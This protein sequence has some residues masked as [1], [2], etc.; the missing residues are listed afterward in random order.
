MLTAGLV[1]AVTWLFCLPGDLFEGDN[2]STVVLDKDGNLLGARIADDGQWRFPPC[3]SVPYKFAASIIEFEDRQFLSHYGVNP[4]SLVRALWGNIKSGKVTSGGSTITMQVIRLSRHGKDRTVWEKLVEAFM[5]TRLETG[6]S[7]REILALYASHA[8]FGGNVVGLEAAAWRYFGC[9]AGELSWAE[10]ATLAVLP[11]SPSNIHPGKNRELLLAKRNRLLDRLLDKGYISPEE[12]ELAKEEPLILEPSALPNYVPHLVEKCHFTCKGQTVRTSIDLG[13]QQQLD[14]CTTLWSNE[15]ATLGISDLAAVVIDVAS[16]DIIAYCGNASPSRARH[17]AMVDIADS[18]RSTGSVLKP[19]LFCASL[20]EGIILPN[21]LMADTPMNINGFTPRNFDLQY[22]G[23]VPAS[24]ALARSLNVPA[25]NMLRQFGVPKFHEILKELGMTTITRSESDYGL[26]IILGG[27][28]GKLAEITGIYASMSRV[29]QSGEDYPLGDRVALWHT[30]EA[31]KGLGR[32]DEIDLRMVR[33]VRKA[34]WKTGTSWGFRDAWAVGVTPDYA[35]GVWAGN[36]DGS[37]AQGL[38]GARTAGPV[39]FDILNLLPEKNTS[40]AYAAE[41]WFLPPLQSEGIE[42]EVCHKSGHLRGL[43]CPQADTLLLPKAS[44]NS[45]PCPYHSGED[46]LFLLPPAMEWYYKQHHPEYNAV[47]A[48]DRP[49]MEF[50]SP[51]NGSHIRLP[52][53]LD[54]SISSIVF[55]LAHRKPGTTVWWHMDGDYI[56]QTKGIHQKSLSPSAGDHVL[57]VVDASG[58]T[59][60]LKFSIE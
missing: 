20:Q 50:I 2:Y 42:A 56:G 33:S 14:R 36:A 52:R 31:L 21:T 12:H 35:I 13:L 57:T 17:G 60:A 41:G 10:S 26:S 25:V 51:E 38:I 29:Y 58:N 39:M 23:A 15:F 8:P 22:S 16:G 1:L 48:K 7:K 37:G 44:M 19:F 32:P 11:N 27:A 30:F 45:A 40:G 54:G 53:Q 9:P 34:A 43:Y 59:L 47:P 4:L 28:E 5:A 6:T 46:G 3:D 24:E 18:P 49:V 55:N